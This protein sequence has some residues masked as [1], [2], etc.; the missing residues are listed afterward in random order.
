MSRS[1]E[2]LIL[3]DSDRTALNDIASGRVAAGEDV[4]KRARAIL[5]MCE[6]QQLKA[7]ALELDMRPNTITDIRKRY[8]KY[9]I[10]SITD[11]ART[12]RPVKIPQQEAQYS[13]EKIIQDS[14]SSK[15]P[16]PSVKDISKQLNVPEATV[17]DILKS[18]GII[19]ERKRIWDF[20]TS[21]GLIAR[22]ID[23][24]GIYLSPMQQLIIVQTFPDS[25]ENVIPDHK[26]NGIVTIHN[27]SL[28]CRIQEDTD[29]DGGIE[30]A[31]SLEAFCFSE[32]KTIAKKSN[33]ALDYVQSVVTSLTNEQGTEYHIFAYGDPIITTGRM[34]IKD[35]R[36]KNSDGNAPVF[37]QDENDGPVDYTRAPDPKK[38][39]KVE[40]AV[41]HIQVDDK[42]YLFAAQNMFLVCKLVL[43]F[44][45]EKGLL[46]SRSL[47]FFS[48]GGKDIRKCIDDIFSFCP[49]TVVL[50][51][52]HLKKHCLELLSMTLYGGKENRPMQYEVRRR[53]FHILWAGNTDGAINFLNT[54]GSD[55]VRNPKKLQELIDYLKNNAARNVIACYALRRKLGLRVSSN[56]VEKANDLIVAS[57]QKGDSMSWSRSGSWGLAAITCMYLNHEADYFHIHH[58]VQP[59]MYTDYGIIFDLEK[60]AA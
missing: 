55:K 13:L 34:F 56:P 42:K 39:P 30:L 58:K 8:L 35:N 29:S 59:E 46:Q 37:F 53:L 47:V 20:R 50:D 38:R 57:R 19:S 23:I 22:Y 43:A 10:S 25:T 60:A 17:R 54:L 52:F 6:G 49:H 9:G 14:F 12:G 27:H 4:V 18:K 45:L 36:P 24:V 7:I 1:V 32:D 31:K 44:L 33:G 28:A 48:D 3:K 11:Q 40:T 26:G 15:T 21:N 16:I 2:A 51:W 41:A 5:K